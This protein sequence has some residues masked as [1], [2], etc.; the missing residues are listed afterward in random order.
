MNALIDQLFATE[1]PQGDPHGRPVFLRVGLD[2]LHR[3]FG[4]SG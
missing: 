3:R 1:K 2:E 4:R